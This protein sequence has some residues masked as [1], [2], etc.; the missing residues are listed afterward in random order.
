MQQMVPLSPAEL[1]SAADDFDR[2]VLDTPGI[3][4]FCSS[5]AWVLSAAEA[6]MPERRPFAFRGTD[7]W[8][9]AAMSQHP[10]GLV[11]VEPLELAWGLASP[12]VGAPA[13]VDEVVALLSSTTGWQVALLAGV[14]AGSPLAVAL[15]HTLPATWERRLG[16]P[17]IRHVASL[18][19]GVDGF[20]GRR[21]RDFRKALRR[22]RRRAADRGVEIATIEPATRDAADA[23]FERVIDVERRSWKA[24]Q[25]VGLS[26]H[27]FADFY[28]RM[29]GRLAERDRLRAVVARH[30]GRDVAYALGAVF[31]GEYRGLQFSYDAALAD[32]SLGSL[33]QVEQI[34]RLC[35]E[36]VVAYDLGTDMDYKRRWAERRVETQLVVVVRR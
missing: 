29:A 21:S 17:T 3:D 6:I 25:G 8:F 24:E 13:V 9:A 15:D 27:A 23:L 35:E 22:A 20:L 33:C 2:V 16:Q 18:E 1:R 5:S 10:S 30:D 11:C 36:N 34:E 26:D 32:L 12:I 28:R 7:G 14:V 4:R 19:G 31:G